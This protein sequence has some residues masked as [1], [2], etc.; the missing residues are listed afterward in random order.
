MPLL[1]LITNTISGNVLASNRVLP[2]MTDTTFAQAGTSLSNVVSST[3]TAASYS[4]INAGCTNDSLYSPLT[5]MRDTA[6]A[7]DSNNAAYINSGYTSA[8]NSVDST[9][10]ASTSGLNSSVYDIQQASRDSLSAGV[11]TY[12]GTI[13][14]INS[15]ISSQV[16]NVGVSELTDAGRVSDLACTAANSGATTSLNSSISD[17]N[18]SVISQAQNSATANA[19]AQS[20]STI[21]NL[22]STTTTTASNASVFSISKTNVSTDPAPDSYNTTDM[23]YQDV[24][25]YIEGV[26]V[27]FISCSISQAIGQL[28][29]ASIQVPPAAGLMDIARYY[30]PKVHVFYDDK[31]TG[32]DRLL[33]W[34]HIVANNYNYSQESGSVSISFEC[35]HKNALLDQLTFE[36]SAGGSSHVINGETLTDT[37]PDMATTQLHNFNSELTIILALQGI[38]GLQTDPKDKISPDNVD[39]LTADPTKLDVRFADFEKRLVGM[40][41]AIMNLWNQVKREIY[42]NERM[43]LIFT[44]MYMPLV[45]DGIAFFDR[46]SGHYFLENQIQTSKMQHCNDNPKPEASKYP[47]MLP[48]AFRMN[49]ISAI[50]TS[51]AVKNLTSLLGFSG[52]FMS[53]YQLFMNFYYGVE[54]ELLTLASPAEIPIDPTSMAN[55]DDPATWRSQT[56][57]AVETIIKPQTPFYYSPMCNVLLPN[58]FT[59]LTV[60][61][62]DGDIPT[63]ITAVSNAA[64]EAT[65]AANSLGLNY[66]APQSIRE[67]VATGREFLD[68][69]NTTHSAA[70]LR[71]TTGSSY[72]IP[73]KYEMG[74]GVK[75]HKLQMPQ[76]LSQFSAGSNEGRANNNDENFPVKGSQDD[77]TLTDLRLAWINRYGY[78]GTSTVGTGDGTT[79]RQSLRNG[80][81]PFSQES[82]IMAYERLLFAAA[83]YEFT[84]E[85]VKSRTGSVECLF[86]PY[87]IPGYPMDIIDRSPNHPSFHAMCASVTHTITSRSISTSVSFMAAITYTEMSNYFIQP[88][89]PWLQGALKLVNV[90]RSTTITPG[91]TTP[92]DEA[93][94]TAPPDNVTG[95]APAIQPGS[96]D[97]EYSIFRDEKYQANIAAQQSQQNSTIYGLTP[98][99]V[100]DSNSG[101][102]TAVYQ[103][104]IGNQRAKTVA[105]QFYRSVLGVTAV[106][107]SDVFD[108]QYGGVKAVARSNCMWSS[109]DAGLGSSSTINGGEANDNLTGVGG[110]R[111]VRRQIESKLGIEDKF[112]I[113]FID[114]TPTNYNGAPAIYE[115]SILTNTTLLEP[116]ASLF[117]DYAEISTL[118]NYLVNTP[119]ATI[120]AEARGSA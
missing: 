90:A 25:V 102:V 109:T 62:S 93:D 55:L 57:M 38:T 50:Q 83:D 23:I 43:N 74:R 21:Q 17:I 39:V 58:M 19:L 28:P 99:P 113:K 61:Q 32:G 1:S 116:G 75:H 13:N 94:Y 64:A 79:Y 91:S 69:S 60:S 35:D 63:R 82:A 92:A 18:S 44:K 3:Q 16:T 119:V 87:I 117:L 51:M 11:N 54:Y 52:E 96:D 107:P 95:G 59:D 41:T 26:Q 111:L 76:W 29:K 2:K 6:L 105:D 47:T 4:A 81:N 97:R 20:T 15:S 106:D 104:L 42:S 36:W 5:S 34:G 7:L 72:N 30:Q 86:N 56:R 37:N 14:D 88:I 48:P 114:L 103:T 115:N 66:R 101:D 46:M 68:T 98:D 45:E 100:Y 40:P 71:D 12:G 80:L 85:V 70:T 10:S 31:N 53:F 49:T 67:S 22:P 120:D 33:F 84:K 78:E 65:N 8:I 9:F 24:K 73:G 77:K 89:H 118:S 27:P 108:F 112:G 110:L